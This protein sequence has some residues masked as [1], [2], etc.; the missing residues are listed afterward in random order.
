M[1]EESWKERLKNDECWEE[2]CREYAEKLGIKL[3]EVDVLISCEDFVEDDELIE[4]CE[5]CYHISIDDYG[6]CYVTY[7]PTFD[8]VP[9][10]ERE[11]VFPWLRSL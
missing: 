1:S 5:G 9:P 11:E 3:S 10:E 8:E 4:M 6:W 7:C 2:K